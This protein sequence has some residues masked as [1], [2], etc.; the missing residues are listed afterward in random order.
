MRLCET[1]RQENLKLL[2]LNSELEARL[3]QL[4]AEVTDTNVKLQN[5]Q[6]D[7]LHKQKEMQ[8][9]FIRIKTSRKMIEIMKLTLDT[10]LDNLKNDK[11]NLMKTLKQKQEELSQA[12]RINRRLQ[13]KLDFSQKVVESAR[14]E[15]LSSFVTS[16]DNMPGRE[17]L[18]LEIEKLMK[19]KT[20]LRSLNDVMTEELNTTKR[21]NEDVNSRLMQITEQL[22][23]TNSELERERYLLEQ[24][25]EKV[26]S[27]I[28]AITEGFIE[29]KIEEEE[30]QISETLIENII[31]NIANTL[32][33]RSPTDKSN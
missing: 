24:E 22:L 14:D 9:D 8:K 26:K 13:E 19:S 5:A 15:A 30:Q 2:V 18:V 28:P 11:L 29:K 32:S 12:N 16:D 3:L 23:A 1:L 7:Y 33:L 31:N 21:E 6:L 17:D 4:S 20:V 27:L 25:R 10:E